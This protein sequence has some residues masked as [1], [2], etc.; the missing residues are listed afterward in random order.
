MSLQKGHSN[1]LTVAISP[2]KCG[3]FA[4]SERPNL[5][6]SGLFQWFKAGFLFWLEN[7]GGGVFVNIIC[8]YPASCDD[9]FC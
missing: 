4:S 3:S 2:S 5:K 9:V 6:N 8:R 1:L 7:F